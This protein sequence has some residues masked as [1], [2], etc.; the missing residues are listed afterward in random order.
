MVHL[1]ITASHSIISYDFIVVQLG[2]QKFDTLIT[3]VAALQYVTMLQNGFTTLNTTVVVIL[4]T[5]T[6]H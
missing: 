4:T 3:T 1:L 5:A 2:G 6:F